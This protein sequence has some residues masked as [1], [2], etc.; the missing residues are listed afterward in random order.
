MVPFGADAVAAASVIPPL[1]YDVRGVLLQFDPPL[2][3]L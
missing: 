1:Y 2:A 3:L